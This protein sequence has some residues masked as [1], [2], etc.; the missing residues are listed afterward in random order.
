MVE[1]LMMSEKLAT[2]GLLKINVIWNVVYDVISSL[3]DVT[4]KIL[5]HDSNYIIE[6]VIWPK[7]SNCSISM[8]EVV[9]TSN[10]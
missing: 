5:S 7:L 1:S 8:R 9:I 2:L 4:N 10:F 3:Y 6:V